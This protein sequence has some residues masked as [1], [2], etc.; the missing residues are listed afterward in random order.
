MW[1]PILPCLFAL[2]CDSNVETIDASPGRAEISMNNSWIQG[3]PTE[4]S[5]RWPNASICNF[6]DWF[7]R[8]PDGLTTTVMAVTCHGCTLLEDPTGTT[9]W[10]MTP[11]KLTATAIT[12]DAITIDI[13]L[14][15]DATGDT[16]TVSATALGDHETA[17]E[18]DCRL[19][20][21]AELRYGSTAPDGGQVTSA[22]AV[23]ACGATRL[24][25]Q[26]IVVF[27]AIRTHRDQ[28][29]FPFCFPDWSCTTG[30]N[31][32]LRPLSQL[33]ITPAPAGWG[34]IGYSSDGKL[35]YFAA[36]PGDASGTIELSAP[37][38]SGDMS[39]ASVVVPSVPQRTSN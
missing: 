12:D 30:W 10:S 11:A 37:L 35:V 32:P 24:P 26:A 7:C 3:R 4:V 28:R 19:I 5:F 33:S 16:Q 18:A 13:A 29:Y 1:R 15:F 9:A 8:W 39:S 22:S 20:D 23:H 31:E 17:L 6:D 14:R 38:L 25:T 2:G 34:Q 36:Y 27:P 21:V